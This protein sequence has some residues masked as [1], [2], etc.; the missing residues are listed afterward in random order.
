VVPPKPVFQAFKNKFGHSINIEWH[1][2][3]EN[4]EALFYIEEAENIAL[5][6]PEG[7]I[8][9]HKKNLLLSSATQAVA[10]QA[11][12]VGELMNLIEIDREGVI[13]FEVIA[14]DG[15]LDRYYLLLD[16]NGTLIDKKKL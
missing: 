9:E 16:S 2:E 13:H 6:T 12:L 14:R 5:F 11:A 8:L 1:R 10:T 3:K 7:K 15:Y 4:F